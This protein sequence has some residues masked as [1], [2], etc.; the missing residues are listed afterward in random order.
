MLDLRD[1]IAYV[2]SNY[3]RDHTLSKARLTKILYLADWRSAIDRSEQVTPI[4]WHFNH[5]GPY[6][7]DVIETIGDDREFTVVQR[8]TSAGDRVDLIT[9]LGPDN[10]IPENDKK[11]LD[12]AISQ[13]RDLGYPNFK[14]LVY[15]TYPIATQARYSDLNLVELAERYRREMNAAARSAERTRVH[16]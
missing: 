2:C 4:E 13:A 16:A 3:E 6:V 9:Y 12:F 10:T 11:A 5:Y 8:T 15:S 7:D 14:R 1:A